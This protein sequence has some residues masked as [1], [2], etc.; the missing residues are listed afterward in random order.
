MYTKIE[1]QQVKGLVDDFDKFSDIACKI[2]P[3]KLNYKIYDIL[4]NTQQDTIGATIIEI[5]RAEIK[6]IEECF[7]AGFIMYACWSNEWQND[8]IDFSETEWKNIIRNT[9]LPKYFLNSDTP[10]CCCDTKEMLSELR[11][12]LVNGEMD[13][14]TALRITE[15]YNSLNCIIIRRECNS[16]LLFCTD[17]SKIVIC[18]YS[19]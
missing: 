8:N 4:K 13:K 16:K 2:V 5:E 12:S 17:K 14:N 7:A 18:E 1:I 9:W 3:H 6:A 10:I 19:L 15:N 11:I